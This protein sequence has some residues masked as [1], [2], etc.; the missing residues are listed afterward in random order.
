MYFSLGTILQLQI[1]FYLFSVFRE[2]F[3]WLKIKEDWLK[4]QLRTLSIIVTEPNSPYN[5]VGQEICKLQLKWYSHESSIRPSLLYVNIFKHHISQYPARDSALNCTSAEQGI[6]CWHRWRNMGA[7]ATHKLLNWAQII[8]MML[9]LS[10]I[11]VLM[12]HNR[13]PI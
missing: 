2:C 13:I 3:R 1:M 6:L 9:C 7:E 11:N 5:A 12:I 4:Q 10:Y 8:S